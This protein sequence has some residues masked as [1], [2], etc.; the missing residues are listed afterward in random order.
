MIRHAEALLGAL[1]SV[2]ETLRD[3]VIEAC[4]Q[5]EV[6]DL[7]RVVEDGHGDTT[8]ALDRVGEHRL[9]ELFLP[10]AREWTCVLVAEGLPPEGIVLPE[11]T[12]RERAEIVVI[13]DPIDGTRGLMY[14]KRSAWILAGAAPN[15]GDA[16]SLA[17]IDVAVQT[18][19]PILKQHLVD[20]AW[21][22]KG[23]GSAAERLDR[24]TGKRQP[25]RLRPSSA[26]T[27]A[28]GFG[29]LA[30]F[31]PGGRSV[32][33]AIDD[34]VYERLLGVPRPGQAQAFED[35]YICSGGQLYELITGHDRWIAD[36]RP[37][38]R[39]RGVAHGLCAHPYDLCTELIAREAGV[40]V[41]DAA[42]D[43][44]TAP[45]DTTTDVAWVGYAN[46]AIRGMVEP[47]LRSA[48]SQFDLIGRVLALENQ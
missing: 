19:I 39:A 30:R 38:L 6:E 15:R 42:G 28:Q 45:L 21:A 9:V 3:A 20:C 14:Q 40:L 16:T 27:V 23:R 32:L 17:D 25:F 36:L 31:L 22:I 29:G 41:T 11:G 37:L 44:L 18:E 8:F 26:T 1:R 35:Q 7:A 48:L 4:E 5:R 33:A 13:V 12:S 2:Q 47:A 10:V 43:P 34:A 46:A 24:V